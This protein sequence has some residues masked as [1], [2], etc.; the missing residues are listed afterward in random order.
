MGYSSAHRTFTSTSGA[1]SAG[2]S[3]RCTSRTPPPRCSRKT[4]S[5]S[6][7][8]GGRSIR[9]PR[10]SLRNCRKND[11]RW[12]PP[13]GAINSTSSSEPHAPTKTPRPSWP[14]QDVARERKADAGNRAAGFK[15]R[16][17]ELLDSAFLR[18]R[19]AQCGLY[20]AISLAFDR[21]LEEEDGLIQAL[22]SLRS[23]CGIDHEEVRARVLKRVAT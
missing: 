7:T 2:S 12:M 5:F 18:L 9:C 1:A 23:G 11:R 17:R 13:Q 20:T 3:R 14:S 19:G 8:C 21:R 6:T 10:P 4:R 16:N 22:D 15:T